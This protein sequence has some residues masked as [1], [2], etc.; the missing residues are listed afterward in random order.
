MFP[1]DLREQKKKL[2]GMLA[3]IDGVEDLTLTTNGSL[4]EEHAQALADAGLRRHDCRLMALSSDRP[5][6]ANGARPD[7]PD[8]CYGA[9]LKRGE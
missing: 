9:A 7:R 8:S 6:P 5:Q 1:Q 2:I 3:A 4:L